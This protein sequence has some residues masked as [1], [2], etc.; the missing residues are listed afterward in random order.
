[1]QPLLAY[2]FATFNNWE[3]DSSR[4]LS[5]NFCHDSM[6]S[7]ALID[8]YVQ[9]WRD[10]CMLLSHNSLPHDSISLAEHRVP[11]NL[12]TAMASR[13]KLQL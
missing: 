13:F 2:H 1:M 9:F 8:I 5:G 6:V 3:H 12:D 4:I 10:I 7:P 11:D